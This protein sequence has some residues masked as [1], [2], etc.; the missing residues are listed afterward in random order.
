MLSKPTDNKMSMR[1]SALRRIEKT[2]RADFVENMYMCVQTHI[3]VVF[4]LWYNL[5]K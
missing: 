4:F 3:V 1:R 5:L 2:I